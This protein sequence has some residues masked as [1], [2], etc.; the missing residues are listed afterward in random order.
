MANINLSYIISTRNRLPFLKILLAELI[1]QLMPD[2]E[3]VVVDGQSTDGAKEYLQQLFNEGKIHQ[4][5]SEPDKNQAHGWN[6]AL[7]LA[8][9]IIIKKL[10]DDDVFCYSAI[11]E[12][13]AYMLLNTNVDVMLSNDLTSDINNHEI[14]NQQS[15][16]TQ[17]EN[18]KN[19]QA[20]SF[21]FGDVHMLIRKSALSYIGLYSALFTMMDWEYSLRISYLQVNIAYYTGYNALSVMHPQSITSLADKRKIA[22]EGKKGELLYDYAGDS[23]DISM[24]SKIKIAVGTRLSSIQKNNTDNKQLIPEDLAVVYNYYYDY[25]NRLNASLQT[26][27]IQKA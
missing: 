26:T 5:I 6:K 21:T 4:F 20:P 16:F 14:I 1:P 10:I 24:W 19:G 22:Q 3:I 18:W 9:G 15:R 2:E 13:K 8:K 27:F 17:F 11:R 12:C 23:S 25:I 7:L